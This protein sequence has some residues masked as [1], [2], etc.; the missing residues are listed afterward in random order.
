MNKRYLRPIDYAREK[1]ISAPAVT[2]KI[3]KGQ[4]KVVLINGRR[5]IEVD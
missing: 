4:L 1:G 2:Q 5:L 3:N